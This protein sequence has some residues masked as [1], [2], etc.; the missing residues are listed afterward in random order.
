MDFESIIWV[1]PDYQNRLLMV[2]RMVLGTGGSPLAL[3][4]TKHF[5]NVVC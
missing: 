3:R 5:E 2:R 1:L 4:G